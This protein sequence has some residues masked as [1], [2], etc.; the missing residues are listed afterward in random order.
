MLMI[1]NV[2]VGAIHPNPFRDLNTYPWIESKLTQLVASIKEV[3]FWV[4]VIARPHG[5]DYQM[6]FGHHRIE[7]A[8]RAGLKSIP[9]V[10]DD[11][12]DQQMIQY[13]GRENGE[14]YASD[15]LVMLNTWDGAV[16]Y[17]RGS[18][19]VMAKPIEIARLLGWTRHDSTSRGELRMNDV[20][21]ACAAGHA[22]VTNGYV[23]RGD[24]Q[25]LTVSAAFALLTR[26]QDRIE[27]LARLG[28]REGHKPAA[29]K[30]G[31]AVIG[32]ATRTTAR[33]VAEGKVAQRQIR[34]ELDVNTVNAA[35]RT[36]KPVR[37]P[38]FSLF[39]EGLCG[40]IARMLATDSAAEKID[41]IAKALEHIE[42][43]E[44]K[45][46]IRRLHHELT[47][48]GHRSARAIKRTTLGKVV[49][50]KAID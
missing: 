34:T 25:G 5:K 4:G 45:A 16:Q 11:L 19:R 26:A 10:I 3:G 30:Q 36:E 15:F 43:D 22:L 28:A 49:K 41:E 2:A 18:P 50:L 39:A 12:T 13:M 35:M 32:R 33:R 14:D 1:K 6:A 17:F 7:A 44:D 31:Q 37:T 46:T 47:E 40:Q 20:A 38:L 24:L 27:G 42:L 23:G 21:S 29:T 8:K 48:L 9:L